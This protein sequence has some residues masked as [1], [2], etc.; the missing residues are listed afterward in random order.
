M[1]KEK[2]CS[3]EKIGYLRELPKNADI[4]DY[5]SLSITEKCGKQIILYRLLSKRKQFDD[6]TNFTSSWDVFNS[7]L[8]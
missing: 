3:L 6:T 2:M 7:Y 1:S 4:N 5:E 8:N